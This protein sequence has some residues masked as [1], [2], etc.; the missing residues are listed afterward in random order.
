MNIGPALGADIFNYI[1]RGQ[2][3]SPPTVLYASVGTVA[4]GVATE[5]GV[6][7]RV[8]FRLNRGTFRPSAAG[9]LPDTTVST[10][11]ACFPED[12]NIAV[13]NASEVTSPVLLLY[14]AASGGDPYV[15]GPVSSGATG[16]YYT[17]LGDLLTPYG[18]STMSPSYIT[19]IPTQ[20]GVICYTGSNY[21]AQQFWAM[22][23]DHFFRSMDAVGTYFS[24]GS[25]PN[26]YLS[27]HAGL[28]FGASAYTGRV[29]VTRSTGSWSAPAVDAASGRSYITNTNAITVGP[30]T[31][32]TSGSGVGT[33]YLQIS[34]NASVP[35]TDD[36]ISQGAFEM[37]TVPGGVIVDQVIGDYIQFD[38][39]TIKVILY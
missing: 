20:A 11:Y 1:Y 36:R 18:G 6:S 21:G 27:I 7:A 3:V 8:P 37:R 25:N 30:F 34:M 16:A 29:A 26:I 23:R 14:K 15:I 2:A 38:P 39:G 28:G 10:W 9:V 33:R 4:T 13:T 32:G 5:V 19:G 12:L 35:G 22:I 17:I 31:S 24:V